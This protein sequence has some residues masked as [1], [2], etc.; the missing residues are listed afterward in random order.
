MNKLWLAKLI[1]LIGMMIVGS[2]FIY[3][4][5]FDLIKFELGALAV[6]SAVFYFG[7]LMEKKTA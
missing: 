5:H 3:G 7:W 2:G 1:E 6:G 4:I